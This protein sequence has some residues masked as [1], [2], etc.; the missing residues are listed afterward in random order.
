MTR[1]HYIALAQALKESHA[2]FEVIAAVSAVLKEDN[3]RFDLQ[4]FV[5]V[6][7]GQRDLASHP[8]KKVMVF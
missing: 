5:E 6:I 2:T 1:K 3:S 4:H 7:T 8:S